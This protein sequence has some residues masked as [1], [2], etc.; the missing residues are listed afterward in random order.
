MPPA[1]GW[2]WVSVRQTFCKADS[3]DMEHA[4]AMSTTV[5]RMVRANKL[6]AGTLSPPS[7]S[8]SSVPKVSNMLK[9]HAV[10][11]RPPSLP[12]WRAPADAHCCFASTQPSRQLPLGPLGWPLEFECHRLAS[13]LSGPRASTLRLHSGDA[14]WGLCL[15]VR[16]MAGCTCPALEILQHLHLASSE[17]PVERCNIVTAAPCLTATA[18]AL[19]HLPNVSSSAAW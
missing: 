1:H 19:V 5:G 13:R 17:T 15:L 14:A 6:H 3:A 18:H 9:T 4:G 10:R 11:C 16:T 12:A 7:P 2:G 8:A